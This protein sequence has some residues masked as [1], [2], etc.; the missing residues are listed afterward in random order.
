[1]QVER[2]WKRKVSIPAKRNYIWLY[3]LIVSGK[4]IVTVSELE[5]MKSDYTL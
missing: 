5:I 1:M 3:K 4:F 2:L